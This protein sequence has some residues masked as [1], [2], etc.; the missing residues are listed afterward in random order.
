MTETQ[1][2][3]PGGSAFLT[4]H[5]V[6]L[7]SLHLLTQQGP[8]GCFLCVT[9]Y[10]PWSCKPIS[11]FSFLLGVY[12]R[13]LLSWISSTSLST[14][15]SLEFLTLLLRGQTTL[16]S[17]FSVTHPFPHEEHGLLPSALTRQ[18]PCN[19][20]LVQFLLSPTTFLLRAPFRT[21]PSAF[22]F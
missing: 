8:N 5:V 19:T 22:P 18:Q 16:E 2:G 3:Q 15:W 11:S 9:G 12:K 7:P 21:V 17:A 20:Q 1:A 14:F 13:L 10:A 4:T 6:V